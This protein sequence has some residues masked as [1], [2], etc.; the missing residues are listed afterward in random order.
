MIFKTIKWQDHVFVQGRKGQK[1]PKT[2]KQIA[3]QQKM[4]SI[5]FHVPEKRGEERWY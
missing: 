3:D 5:R 4:G 2:G 1:M